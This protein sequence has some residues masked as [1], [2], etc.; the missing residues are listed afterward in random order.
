MTVSAPV[1]FNPSPP[2]CVVN[3]RMSIDGSLLN[4]RIK[5]SLSVTEEL[6]YVAFIIPK[7]CWKQEIVTSRP[8]Q[9]AVK[10]PGDDLFVEKPSVPPFVPR[11]IRLMTGTENFQKKEF[12]PLHER[13][14]R[15]YRCTSIKSLH[16]SAPKSW[17]LM[18][19]FRI[20]TGHP[21]NSLRIKWR[22]F[23]KMILCPCNTS[24]KYKL[25][26]ECAITTATTQ[27]AA[28][29]YYPRTSTYRVFF[30]LIVK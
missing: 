28:A 2:T 22:K 29:R 18:W 21:D 25:F 27:D 20:F 4:L 5:N 15:A 10:K 1:K 23:D 11:D 17:I 13:V 7:K 9:G 14:T 6:S 19:R 8:I 26:L 12:S 30:W 24:Y 3:N 16:L